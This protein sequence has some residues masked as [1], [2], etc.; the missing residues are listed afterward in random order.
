MNNSA[1]KSF[2]E[3]EDFV[4]TIMEDFNKEKLLEFTK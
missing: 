3:I 2:E 4:K 1:N